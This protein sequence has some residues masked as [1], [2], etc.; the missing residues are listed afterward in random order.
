MQEVIALGLLPQNMEILPPS[1][2]RI[3]KLIL[4][5]PDAKPVLIDL[6]SSVIHRDVVNVEVRNNEL[7]PEDIHEKAERLDVNCRL[8][9][10]TQVDLEMQANAIEE[11]SGE[12]GG[13]EQ[14]HLNLKGKSVYPI[15]FTQI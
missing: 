5:S 14:R 7:P 9:D 1:D 2:D 4:T 8:A 6:I 12:D 15:I 3:F 10:G 13:D 11:D